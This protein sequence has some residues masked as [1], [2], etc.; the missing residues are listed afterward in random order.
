[1]RSVTLQLTATVPDEF[2]DEDLVAVL[3]KALDG[4]SV[5]ISDPADRETIELDIDFGQPAVV[6]SGPVPEPAV[7]PDPPA[8]PFEHLGS[9]I[10]QGDQCLGHLVHFAGH[11]V[12]EPNLGRVAID[13]QYVDAHNQALDTALLDGLDNRCEIGQG[14]FF[15]LLKND[16]GRPVVKTFTG[17]LVSADVAV[18]GK[19]IT[20]KRQ[21]KT[22]RGRHNDPEN[23]A[24][25]FQRIA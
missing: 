9:L 24:F 15:Y 4:C 3:D 19:T 25:N 5:D 2:T 1:M 20:F 22:F 11:G 18:R 23:G 21:G 13:P 8:V 14:G 12:F 17:Q 7:T 16:A 6:A 10:T